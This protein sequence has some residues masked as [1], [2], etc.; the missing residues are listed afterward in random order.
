MVVDVEGGLW[1]GVMYKGL[2]VGCGLF[3]YVFGIDG[4]FCLVVEGLGVFNGMVFDCDGMIFFMI[5]MLLCYLLVFL[6]NGQIL[7]LFVIVIDFFDLL[8]KFDGMDM[9]FGGSLWVVMWG[10]GCVLCVVCNGVVEQ[11]VW[12]LVMYVS[13]VCV[14]VEGDFWVMIFCVC[15]IEE[16]FV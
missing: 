10:S 3:Y 16:Q 11:E 6:V 12:L 7:G 2:L 14:G 1:I 15:Q 4:L 5:D 9:V 13:S 8:G